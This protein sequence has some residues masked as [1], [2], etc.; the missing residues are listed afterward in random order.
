[1]AAPP[2]PEQDEPRQSD[3][4]KKPQSTAEAR[5][6][7]RH[8]PQSEKYFSGG[9]RNLKVNPTNSWIHNQIKQ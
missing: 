1:M 7:D 3:K 2:S 8:K 9:L 4:P 6:K 5:L